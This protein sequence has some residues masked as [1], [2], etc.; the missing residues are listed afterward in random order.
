MKVII[1][2][3]CEGTPVSIDKE[4]KGVGYFIRQNPGAERYGH[5]KIIIEPSNSKSSHNWFSW[6]VSEETIPLD[7]FDMV[8]EGIKSFLREISDS[9]EKYLWESQIRVVGGSYHPVDSSPKAYFVAGRLAIKDA[10]L[11][12][13]IIDEERT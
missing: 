4:I 9:S 12:A 2:L 11:N 10:L 1:A 5:V 6:E 7:L 3:E 8:L 13:G